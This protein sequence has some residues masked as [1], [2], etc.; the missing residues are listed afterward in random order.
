M[1]SA[2]SL[3][4][5]IFKKPFDFPTHPEDRI[6]TVKIVMMRLKPY[7]GE[8]D[9]TLKIPKNGNRNIYEIIKEQVDYNGSIVNS[10]VVR[11]VELYIEIH[12]QSNIDKIYPSFINIK[13][14]GKYELKNT[15]NIPQEI[16]PTITKYINYWGM[17]NEPC[18]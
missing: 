5:D 1:K 9:I 14:S 11:E 10:L 3:N 6:K 2:T 8:C 18:S 7:N 15:K 4:L 13:S 12:H 16:I 17:L